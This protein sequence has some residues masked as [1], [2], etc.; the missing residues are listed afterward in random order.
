M[1]NNYIENLEKKINFFE[2]YHDIIDK[3]I[4]IYDEY[5]TQ[6]EYFIDK[7]ENR[8]RKIKYHI[9]LLNKKLNDLIERFEYIDIVE[10]IFEFEKKMKRIE[11]KLDYLEDNRNCKYEVPKELTEPILSNEYTFSIDS[12]SDSF[13]ETVYEL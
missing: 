1:D 13:D 6:F 5:T 12:D 11:S 2:Q 8:Y 9:N 10:K 3:H 4:N 7:Y